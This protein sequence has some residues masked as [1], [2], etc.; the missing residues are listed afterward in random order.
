MK[1][2]N[3]CHVFICSYKLLLKTS[4][5]FSYLTYSCDNNHEA[6]EVSTLIVM[7]GFRQIE[8]AIRLIGWTP[9]IRNAQ[10]ISEPNTSSMPYNHVKWLSL[11]HQLF[12][13]VA[14]KLEYS[15][16][17]GREFILRVCSFA[18]LEP[19]TGCAMH[20]N[21]PSGLFG[22]F[23]DARINVGLHYI[24]VVSKEASKN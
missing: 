11:K 7:M 10:M 12:A 16:L 21:S 14:C 4:Q 13:I 20:Y 2:S 23:H 1:C 15:G 18:D 17:M 8:V 9:S 3:W 22:S 19:Y 24:Q 6:L 5:T